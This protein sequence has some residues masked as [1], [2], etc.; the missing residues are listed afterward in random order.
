MSYLVNNKIVKCQESEYVDPHYS[1]IIRVNYPKTKICDKIAHLE[2]LISKNNIAINDLATRHK[3]IN[4]DSLALEQNIHRLID[5]LGNFQE[6]KE[7]KQY[8]LAKL[9]NINDQS[10]Q[11]F[12]SLVDLI[13][14]NKELAAYG[15]EFKYYSK[16]IFAGIGI[17][18]IATYFL[19]AYGYIE[20][21]DKGTLNLFSLGLMISLPI[22]FS[23]IEH[24]NNVNAV[25][26]VMHEDLQMIDSLLGDIEILNHE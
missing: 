16:E 6:Q 22:I 13:A 24:N 4:Q 14:E 9:K 23:T 8:D 19:G 21:L 15:F 12:K 1:Y 20:Q 10:K 3:I 5:V 26:S 7:S 17:A 25:F 11:H 2:E 18:F